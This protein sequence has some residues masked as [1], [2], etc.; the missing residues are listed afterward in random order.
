[1]NQKIET[2]L[3]RASL[4]ETRSKQASLKGDYDRAEKLRT[5]ALQLTQEARRVEETR[6]VDKR[7]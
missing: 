5:K 2:L 6:K 7:T 3:N 4:W 1:M